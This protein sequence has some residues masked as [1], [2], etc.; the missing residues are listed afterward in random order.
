MMGHIIE[1]GRRA[2]LRKWPFR[3]ARKAKGDWIGERLG[4]A[5]RVE[6]PSYKALGQWS[7]QGTG[8]VGVQR[9]AGRGWSE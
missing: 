2:S 4:R 9:V 6:G 7:R 8:M 3:G 5:S 1:I